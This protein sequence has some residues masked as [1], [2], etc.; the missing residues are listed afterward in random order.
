MEIEEIWKVSHGIEWWFSSL[1]IHQNYLEC[2]LNRLLS[3]I[4]RVSVFVGLGLDPQIYVSNMFPGD[5]DVSGPGTT[6]C[7][8]LI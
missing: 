6:V 1:N 8:P 5:A 3:P 2:L 4:P 7:K